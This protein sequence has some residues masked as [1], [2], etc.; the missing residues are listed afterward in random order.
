MTTAPPSLALPDSTGPYQWLS[1]GPAPPEEKIQLVGDQATAQ[2][3]LRRLRSHWLLYRGDYKNARQ[4]LAAVGRRLA[5]RREAAMTP[6]EL[7]HA[8]RLARQH[9]HDTLSRLVVEL[10]DACR[11]MLRAAPDV[12]AAYRWRW[13]PG[14]G[15][16][17]TPLRELLGV[18]GA[19]EWHRKGLEVV[20][21]PGRLHPHYGVFTPTRGVYPELLGA[22]PDP[23]GK[24]VF[25]IGTGTGVL[26]FLL[27]ARGAA[28]AVAT[29]VDPAAVASAREDARRLGLA[30]RFEA[31]ELDL[32]PEGQAD[33]VVCNPPWLPE[34]IR[35][36]L[37]A[38]VFD[39]ESR[40]LSRFLAGLS[41]H[42]APGGVGYLLISNLA[43]LLGLRAP[44]FLQRELEQAGLRVDWKKEA[45]A[46][47]PR[48]KDPGDRLHAVRSREQIA[49]Y[50]LAV[51]A[52]R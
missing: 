27:L 4:L 38:A 28:R 46:S 1:D 51:A 26:A 31:R 25:D 48:S 2:E 30:E 9:E 34:A 12:A 29:D 37:D 41:A 32:F 10:D 22:I 44:D 50:A 8:E 39:P 21:L 43:E 24:Q 11:L 40:F 3:A 36:R 45:P 6:L 7:F 5:R 23:A 19:H 20:G 15:R 35:G 18:Q 13:G 47:H 49:L 16:S 17:V 33:I 14:A 52:T 42:L